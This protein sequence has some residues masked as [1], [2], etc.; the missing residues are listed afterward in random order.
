MDLLVLAAQV[1]I[2]C[3]P[4]ALIVWYI[5]HSHRVDE[6]NRAIAKAIA[7]GHIVPKGYQPADPGGTP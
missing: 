2:A 5:D 7:A 4:F 1:A 3:T 6:K